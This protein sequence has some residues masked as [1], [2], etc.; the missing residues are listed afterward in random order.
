MKLYHGT[1]EANLDAILRDGIV[2]R[3]LRNKNGN[4]EHTVESN[5]EVVY[6]TNCY[7]AYFALNASATDAGDHFEMTRGLILEIDTDL[8]DDW[9]LVPDE[10]VMEQAGR[11]RD[12]LP[13]E[14]TMEERTVFYR[15]QLKEHF[16]RGTWQASIDGMGTCGHWGTVPPEAITRY[17]VIDWKALP[18]VVRELAL[19]PCITLMNYHVLSKKYR[20]VTAWLFKDRTSLEVFRQVADWFV[21][22]P[23]Y[24]DFE[25]DGLTVEVTR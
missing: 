18:V 24:V 8:V 22:A 13:G 10:D 15:K 5:P 21:P 4:W 1:S 2:P 25:H 7:A 14:W 3:G 19:D 17:V 16:G 9:F 20:D 11:D 23:E 6:L 12:D